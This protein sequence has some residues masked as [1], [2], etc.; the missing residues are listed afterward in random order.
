MALDDRELTVRLARDAEDIAA[1]QRLRYEVFV[2]ELGGGGTL[3]DHENRLE[4]ARFDP[5]FDHLILTDGRREIELGA[6]LPPGER[7]DLCA[8]LQRR[9]TAMR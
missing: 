2:E 4:C 1:A 7:R 6:F 9:L 3:V 5:F 8:D